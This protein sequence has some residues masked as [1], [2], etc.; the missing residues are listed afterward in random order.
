MA[1]WHPDRFPLSTVL[2][3]FGHESFPSEGVG[4]IVCR[5]LPQVFAEVACPK[6]LACSN[7]FP[8]RQ[9][10]RL[11]IRRRGNQPILA[12][13][14]RPRYCQLHGGTSGD[15]SVA[16]AA[17]I[18]MKL[19]LAMTRTSLSSSDSAAIAVPRTS[20][21]IPRGELSS[22][23]LR[24]PQEQRPTGIVEVSHIEGNGHG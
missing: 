2:A 8:Y 11:E 24:P 16:T 5:A 12:A 23:R 15:R 10:A 22:A 14:V 1:K 20:A 9:Q 6:R 21:P 19:G 13:R 4:R 17:P 3:L 18:A 7:P